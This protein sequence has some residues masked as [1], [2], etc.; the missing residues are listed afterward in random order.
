MFGRRRFLGLAGAG[1]AA[2]MARSASFAAETI[3]P[4]KPQNVLTPEQAIE[5]LL[6]GNRRYVKGTMKRHDFSTERQS[7]A[8]GQNP[9]AAVLGCADSRIAPEFAFDA[10]RGD[11]FVVRVA[12]NFL[13]NDGLA[14][15]EY[16][17]AVLKTPLL[18]VLGH[19]ACGAVDAVV[20]VVKKD[21][22]LLGHLPGLI[23]NLRPAVEKAES[24]PGDILENA[25]KANVT[26][27]VEK[28]KAA[29]PVIAA[30][31]EEKKVRVA[32]AIYRLKTG[33][34]DIIA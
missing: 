2:A 18:V 26:L 34:V 28:L 31:V 20:K 21:E 22:K 7:L 8:L 33:H 29:G 5:R 10:S 13:S 4:P 9:Y 12:G 27:T 23:E 3:S 32:G 30:L 11:V 25:I 6:A 19:E 14:S 24:E 16:T 17:T 15:L 1:L